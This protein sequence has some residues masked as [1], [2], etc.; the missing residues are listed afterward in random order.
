MGNAWRFIWYL[1]VEVGALLDLLARAVVTIEVKAHF[2]C[3]FLGLAH[4]AGFVQEGTQGVH[5][6]YTQACEE[7]HSRLCI[8]RPHHQ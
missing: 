1:F 3:T 5:F 8:D 4:S 7:L 2:A 6:G